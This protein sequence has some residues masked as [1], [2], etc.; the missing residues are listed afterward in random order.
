MS[1]DIS[2]GKHDWAWNKRLETFHQQCV[3]ETDRKA[4]F[5]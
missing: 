1:I 5:T 4:I 2:D 3:N